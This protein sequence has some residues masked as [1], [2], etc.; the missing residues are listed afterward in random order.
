MRG[1]K[2]ISFTVT[3][4]TVSLIAAFIP[5]LMMGGVIGRILNPFAITVSI[6]LAISAVVSLSARSDAR[7]PPPR[8][9]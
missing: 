1:A 4:I 7:C 6:A 5:L 8:K 9:I 3:S 2:E